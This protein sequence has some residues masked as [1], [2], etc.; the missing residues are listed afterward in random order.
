MGVEWPERCYFFKCWA[1]KMWMSN[2]CFCLH[3]WKTELIWLD[4]L[5][6][7]T[8]SI[9]L[10]LNCKWSISRNDLR[11]ID[12]NKEYYE[13]KYNDDVQNTNTSNI[14]IVRLSQMS[15]LSI[16]YYKSCWHPWAGIDFYVSWIHQTTS[17]QIFQS[18]KSG[19][20][21]NS[22]ISTWT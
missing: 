22:S 13:G 4:L 3:P 15:S 12:C 21:I 18:S 17:H 16:S 20:C 7:S 10:E 14:L 11:H 9:K 5:K 6:L 8:P 19:L 1:V 2:N